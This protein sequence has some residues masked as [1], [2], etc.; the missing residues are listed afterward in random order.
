M[1]PNFK[2]LGQPVTS[3]VRLLTP[4]CRIRLVFIKWLIIELEAKFKDQDAPGGLKNTCQC[5]GN[6]QR[7]FLLPKIKISFLVFWGH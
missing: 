2:I 5:I 3:E 1:V 4:N 6:L 7:P